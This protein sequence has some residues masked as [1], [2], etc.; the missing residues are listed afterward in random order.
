[1]Y[2]EFCDASLTRASK[3]AGGKQVADRAREKAG[4]SGAS[5]TRWKYLRRC[6]AA[7]R[8]QTEN[9]PAAR[10]PALQGK[11]LF[12]AT[13]DEGNL[14]DFAHG[15]FD[16]QLLQECIGCGENLGFHLLAFGFIDLR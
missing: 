12:D 5:T 10:P 15:Y 6:N 2:I 3:S 7:A 11:E 16:V 4:T 8:R 1:M 9:K 13:V 14:D